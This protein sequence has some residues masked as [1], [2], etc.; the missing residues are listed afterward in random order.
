MEEFVRIRRKHHG[1]AS[2]KPIVFG[3]RIDSPIERKRRRFARR[4]NKLAAM[5]RKKNR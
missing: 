5:S 1:R 2:I 3:A 4:K